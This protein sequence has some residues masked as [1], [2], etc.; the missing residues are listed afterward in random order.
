VIHGRIFGKLAGKF[1]IQHFCIDL[2]KHLNFG[3]F[4]IK[5]KKN[6]KSYTLIGEFALYPMIL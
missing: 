3:I 6:I 1:I 4:I 5:P 2:Q